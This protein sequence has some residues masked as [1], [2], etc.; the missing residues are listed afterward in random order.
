MCSAFATMVPINIVLTWGGGGGRDGIRDKNLHIKEGGHK[1]YALITPQLHSCLS[2]VVSPSALFWGPVPFTI[3]VYNG[4]SPTS[5]NILMNKYAD[6]ITCG[7]PVGPNVN[8]YASREVDSI[9]V[10]G[11]KKEPVI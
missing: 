1:G 9:K 11:V 7:I 6:D 10:W 8:D 2:I 4:K 3:M 5:Q